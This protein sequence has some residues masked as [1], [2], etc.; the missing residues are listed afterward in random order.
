MSTCCLK[1]PRKSKGKCHSLCHLTIAN[2]WQLPVKIYIKLDIN[3]LGLKMS[4][5]CFLILEEPNIVLDKKHQTKIPGIICWNVI[6]LSYQAF[7]EKYGLD[8]FKSFTCPKGGNPLLFSQL[9]LFHYAETLEDHT[10]GV[11]SICHH[12]GIDNN[13]K[14]THLAKIKAQPPFNRKNGFKG[15]VTV[16]NKKEPICIPRSLAITTLAHTQ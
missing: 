12:S 10:M 13:W 15:Q 14:L 4:N 7:V 16:G 1:I 6:W 9:C 8:V 5:A 11:Q 2:D 3:F